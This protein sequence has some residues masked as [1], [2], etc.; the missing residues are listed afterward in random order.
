MANSLYPQTSPYYLSDIINARFLD[1]MN[2]RPI[3]KDPTDIYWEITTVYNLRPDLL[4]YDLYNDSRLWW[5]F[6]NRNP[7]TL[8]DP[9]FNFVTGTGIYIPKLDVLKQVLGL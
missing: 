1:M 4:A 3:P 2:N 9:M 8:A 5:V 6:G 7:N